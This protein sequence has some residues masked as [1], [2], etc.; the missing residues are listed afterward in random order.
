MT[1]NAYQLAKTLHRLSRQLRRRQYNKNTAPHH[2]HSHLLLLIAETPGIIQRDLAIKLDI[3][4]S[5]MT[6]TLVK[7]ENSGLIIREHDKK[8]Q[9]VMHIFLTEAGKNS[10]KESHE[11][12]LA[13]NNSLFDCLSTEEI[14]QMLT[15]GQKLSDHLASVQGICNKAHCQHKHRHNCGHHRCQMTESANNNNMGQ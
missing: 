11:Q 15:I 14:Q 5:S 3:R 1:T 7:L 9:R 12:N 2:D 6:E 13:L 10:T 4:P 8:D